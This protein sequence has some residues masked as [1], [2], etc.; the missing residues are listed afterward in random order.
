MSNRIRNTSPYP[1][2]QAPRTTLYVDRRSPDLITAIA[3][4]EAEGRELTR[5][6]KELAWK[7]IMAAWDQ[8][9]EK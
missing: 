5:E 6:Q 9:E 1:Y 8:S 7:L 2:S 3:Q 4:A